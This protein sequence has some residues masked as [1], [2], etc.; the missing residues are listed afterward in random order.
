MMATRRF[1]QDNQIQDVQLHRSEIFRLNK[2][3]PGTEIIC[4]GGT[5]WVTQSGDIKDYILSQ[6]QKFIINHPDTVLI[7]AVPDATLRIQP[8]VESTETFSQVTPSKRPQV[9]NLR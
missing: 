3:R 5:V 9:P 2:C 8:P 7:E 6:G 1:A 4:T